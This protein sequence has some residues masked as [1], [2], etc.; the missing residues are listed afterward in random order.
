ML[1]KTPLSAIGGLSEKAASV[2][3][4]LKELA[5]EK[6][7]LILC[8]LL[9]K[10]EASVA[11]LSE[12]AGLGQSAMSQHLARLRAMNMVKFRRNGAAVYYAVADRKL[13]TLMKTLKTLYC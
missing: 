13:A 3:E 7:L 2:A 12:I 11:E 10:G 9:E 1:T 5:N 8:G 4:I 6:R